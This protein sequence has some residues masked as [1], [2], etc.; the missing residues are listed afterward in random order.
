MHLEGGPHHGIVCFISNYSWFD[1]LS[2][3]LLRQRF[4]DEF[5]SGLGRLLERRQVQDR[6]ANAGRE[7]RSER[8]HHGSQPRGYS[9]RDGDYIAGSHASIKGTAVV[10]YRDL[11]GQSKREDLLASLPRMGPKLY[12]KVTPAD[13]QVGVPFRL[14]TAN[15]N[16]LA[17]P[18]LTELFPASF[19]GVK[20]S[21]DQLVVDI[22]RK[23]LESRMGSYFDPTVSHQDMATI[24]GQAM[25][26]TTTFKA[27]DTRE[28]LQKRGILNSGFVR[29]AYRPFDQR[30]LYWEPETR[31]LD[32]NRADYVKHVFE[33]NITGASAQNRK[34][35]IRHLLVR[36]CAVCT[37]L[38]VA[39]TSF[40]C[41][42]TN[43]PR[44]AACLTM[45]E[46]TPAAVAAISPI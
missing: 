43:G 3:P 29:F 17:W 38:N 16:Y 7:A 21:R 31:L 10:A 5:D 6:Q 34:D 26:D 13:A 14:L 36:G 20:T 28:Y 41:F 9:G 27:S 42:F 30:W 24:C 40:R 37:F 32:R 44:V 25:A 11:W 35:L 39:P 15:T 4:L 19:P 22:D 1:G 12:E 23:Q 33:G 8:V 18:L 2:F 46:K 45:K